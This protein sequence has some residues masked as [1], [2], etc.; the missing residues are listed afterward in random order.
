MESVHEEWLPVKDWEG[1]YEVSN[2]GRVKVLAHSVRHWCGRDIP[3][4]ERIITLTRHSAGYRIVALRTGKKFYVHRLVLA[5]FAG[6]PPKGSCDINHI[7]GD[8]ADNRLENL[9]YCDRHHNIHHAIRTG[10]M[11]NACENNGMAKLTSEQV[12]EARAMYRRGATQPEIAKRL[13][14]TPS[15]IGSFCALGRWKRERIKRCSWR[16]SNDI[17]RQCISLGA[18]G[19]SLN[20]ISAI[21][22]VPRNTA[23]RYV[24]NPDKYLAKMN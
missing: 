2:L 10:L 4:P 22:G 11:D 15:A 8:K 7:N 21:T 19:R 17:V 6:P 5:A 3:K 23:V 1:Q 20:E 18:Q 14:V 9:E 24:N 16:W 13:G 12:D